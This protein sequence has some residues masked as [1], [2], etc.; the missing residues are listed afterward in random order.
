MKYMLLMQFSQD[1]AGF[2]P[3][4]QWTKDEIAAHI[5]FM[6]NAD[7]EIAARGKLIDAQGLAGPEQARI[8]R[9]GT[10]GGPAVVTDGPY[11]ETKEFLAGYWIL[12]CPTAEAAYDLAAYLST[13]PGPGGRPLNMPIHVQPV[14]DAPPGEEG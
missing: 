6:R 13:A 1:S 12:D 10:D 4:D 11:P 5:A 3:L 9:A 8:V 14:L 2:P 7:K